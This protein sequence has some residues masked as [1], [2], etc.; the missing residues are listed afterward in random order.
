VG[1]FEDYGQELKLENRTTQFEGINFCQCRPLWDGKMWRFVRDWK[2]VLSQGCCGLS[3]WD[4]PKFQKYMFS[5]V[6]HCEMALGYG[7][8]V[9][10]SFAEACIRIGGG[11]HLDAYA[12]AD[13]RMRMQREL[14][15]EHKLFGQMRAV[16]VTMEARLSFERVFGVAI[17]EQLDI[18]RRL[19]RWSPVL[20]KPIDLPAEW[21]WRWVDLSYP[22]F[23]SR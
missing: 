16:R 12:D 4:N 1:C 19:Q 21:D 11:H 3:K 22:D 10:Q 2:K 6:G 5:A 7:L 15:R 9:F 14:A 13:L 17:D 8:P 23:S 18:E 20:C